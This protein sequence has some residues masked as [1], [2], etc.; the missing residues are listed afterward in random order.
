MAKRVSSLFSL[1]LTRDD[2]GREHEQISHP[3]GTECPHTSSHTSI[4]APQKLHKHHATTSSDIS[5]HDRLPPLAPP[6]P[7][8]SNEGAY[9]PPSSQRSGPDSRLGSRTSSPISLNLVHSRDDSRSRPQ[10]P[11]ST[12]PP[13]G[14]SIGSPG[15]PLTAT[16][17]K[18]KKKS[19]G[20]TKHERQSHEEGQSQPK[21]WIAGIRELVAYDLTPLLMGAKVK[22]SIP[23]CWDFAK[24]DS[25]GS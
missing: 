7:P 14:A 6:P 13:D 19:W 24:T 20:A 25:P 11:A 16:S 22:H 9:R 12:V 10:S 3:S 8:V 5:L 4:A 2:K 17:T 18:F 15:R 1:S 21:A 23:R